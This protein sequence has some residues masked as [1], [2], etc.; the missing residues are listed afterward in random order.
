MKFFPDPGKS[1]NF[2]DGQGNLESQGKAR[3]FE[4]KW[5]RQSSENLL[6][7]FKRGKDSLS[8]SFSSLGVTLK[9]KNLLPEGANSFL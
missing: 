8:P 7:L 4:N 6:I 2:V 3:E 9:G 1:V 5:L